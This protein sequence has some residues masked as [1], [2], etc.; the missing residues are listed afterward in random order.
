[1][2]ILESKLHP[3]KY[4][5]LLVLVAV[6]CFGV[7]I[8]LLLEVSGIVQISDKEFQNW[9]KVLAA[10]FIIFIIIRLLKLYLTAAVKLKIFENHLK[11]NQ[12]RI[13]FSDIRSV[14]LI[15]KVNMH[16]FAPFP[17]N[18]IQIHLKNG[19]NKILFDS[20]YSNIEEIKQCL[21]QLIILKKHF[22]PYRIREIKAAEIKVSETLKYKGNQLFSFHGLALWLFV[23]LFSS[24]LFLVEKDVPVFVNF[25]MLFVALLFFFLFS[26]FLNYFLI[27]D[28]FIVVKNHNLLWKKR[29]IAFTDI[30]EVFIEE[31]GKWP[32]T[33]VVFTKDFRK[34]EFPASTLRKKQWFGLWRALA[35]QKIRVTNLAR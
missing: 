13:E 33:L 30:K 18:G 10:F 17:M 26:F 19:E 15:G 34:H 6:F 9:I 3:I 4:Y 28:E 29:I 31:D 25:I 7:S 14:Q 12:I 27:S 8:L 32:K 11:Y 35:R 16:F 1:M 24:I 20:F 21:E 5:L 23:L 22:D 2:A